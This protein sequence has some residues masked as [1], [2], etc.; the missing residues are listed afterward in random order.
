M[1]ENIYLIIFFFFLSGR[2]SSFLELFLTDIE[3][4]TRFLTKLVWLILYSLFLLFFLLYKKGWK[5]I[6]EFF[7]KNKLLGIS[8]L[9]IIFSSFLSLIE[10]YDTIQSFYGAVYQMILV[11]IAVIGAVVFSSKSGQK[12]S[13]VVVIYGIILSI[14]AFVQFIDYYL[15]QNQGIVIK[16]FNGGGFVPI[17]VFN[18]RTSD[19]GI[20]LRPSSLMVDPNFLSPF[21]VISML[22]CVDIYRKGRNKLLVVVSFVVIFAAFVLTMSRTG[23]ISLVVGM[24]VYIGS[25]YLKRLSV[26][27]FSFYPWILL[28]RI[29]AR[30]FS[31]DY[32]FTEHIEYAKSAWN[33]FLKH[34]LLGKGVGSFPSYYNDNINP[35]VSYGSVHS[36]VLKILAEMG[37]IG[38]ISTVYFLV[39]VAIRL[40]KNKSSLFFSILCVIIVGNFTYDFLATPWVW[41]ILGIMIS[42]SDV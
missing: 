19:I 34:P 14:I 39:L 1:I 41:F 32:S 22:F 21:L 11:S 20:F 4:P 36:G 31:M 23:I 7:S 26:K 29:F 2:I 10:S 35:L 37:I 16:F 17:K 6:S 3:I 15:N 9:F 30:F 24:F 25:L 18:L 5:R 28:Q 38:F 13:K 8:L 27:V 12:I 33:I 42:D 40:L